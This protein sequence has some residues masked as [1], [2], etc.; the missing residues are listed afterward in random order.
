MIHIL[1]NEAKLQHIL[2]K[3]QNLDCP[4]HSEAAQTFKSE[5]QKKRCQ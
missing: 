5:D 1:K 4:F 3:P 2:F